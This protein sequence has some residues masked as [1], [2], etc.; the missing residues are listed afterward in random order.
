MFQY[1][2]GDQIRTARD[3]QYLGGDQIGTAIDVPIPW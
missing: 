1:L 3:V 2:G